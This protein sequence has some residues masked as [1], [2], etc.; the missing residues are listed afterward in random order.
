[1]ITVVVPLGPVARLE[2]SGATTAEVLADLTAVERSEVPVTLGR[3]L[4]GTEVQESLGRNLGAE[5][6]E[7]VPKDANPEAGMT[8]TESTQRGPVER[9]P[10]ELPPAS[11]SI[12]PG[13]P[14][15]NGK[16]AWLRTIEVNG[17]PTPVFIHP[18]R[19]VDRSLPRTDDPNDPRLASGEAVF[20]APMR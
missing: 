13:A 5:L 12:V 2:V 11:V 3:V 6:I 15:I 1:M 9:E 20:F 17:K 4:K 7:S 16:P 10:E 14:V 18:S 8:G 19:N